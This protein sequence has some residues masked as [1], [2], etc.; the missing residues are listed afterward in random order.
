[1]CIEICPINYSDNFRLHYNEF[2]QMYIICSSPLLYSS[3]C[4]MSAVGHDVISSQL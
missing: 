1:M 3:V 4:H 2:R